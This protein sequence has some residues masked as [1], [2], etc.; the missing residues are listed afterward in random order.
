MKEAEALRAFSHTFPFVCKLTSE[1]IGYLPHVIRNFIDKNEPIPLCHRRLARRSQGYG[2]ELAGLS[3]QIALQTFIVATPKVGLRTRCH[4]HSS[5]TTTNDIHADEKDGDVKVTGVPFPEEERST[6]PA[7]LAKAHPNGKQANVLSAKN[8]KQPVPAQLGRFRQRFG[9][10]ELL[11]FYILKPDGRVYMHCGCDLEEALLDFYLWKTAPPLVSASTGATELLGKPIDPRFRLFFH[12]V[13]ERFNIHVLDLYCYDLAGI[14]RDNDTEPR[15]QDHKPSLGFLKSIHEGLKC[16]N[17]GAM[18]CRVNH[19]DITEQ[20]REEEHVSPPPPAQIPRRSETPRRLE[21]PRRSETPRRRPS[22]P[23]G[24]RSLNS[25]S[26][27]PVE[28]HRSR[29]HA[30]HS[31]QPNNRRDDQRWDH[32][33]KGRSGHR[34][35]DAHDDVVRGRRS[36]RRDSRSPD[37]EYYYDQYRRDH[38]RDRQFSPPAQHHRDSR[39]DYSPHASRRGGDTQGQGHH[40]RKRGRPDS[41]DEQRGGTSYASRRGGDP[42][43][44]RDRKR[45]R[46]DSRDEQRMHG[47]RGFESRNRLEGSSRNHRGHRGTS[48]SRSRQD[49]RAKRVSVSPIYVSSDDNRSGDSSRGHPTQY[50]PDKSTRV[51][52]ED[53]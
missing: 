10:L 31:T 4:Y 20:E 35:R 14:L 23:R 49:K 28:D 47:K 39:R 27:T 41:Q 16:K 50:F 46:P 6:A 44:H 51:K 24:R 13:L 7:A 29:R 33:D 45:A 36:H 53:M 15:Q 52:Q 22:T 48:R 26:R 25:R 1:P 9:V 11:E 21:T 12:S 43:G 5:R 8:V 34:D 38:H 17:C 2:S 37:S 18:E 3:L 42:Q 32:G 40:D 19:H 30:H